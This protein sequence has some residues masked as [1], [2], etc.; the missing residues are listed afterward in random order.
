MWSST[1][2]NSRK[3]GTSWPWCGISY[4]ENTYSWFQTSH[5]DPKISADVLI[6][7]FLQC[8]ESTLPIFLQIKAQFLLFLSL[9]GCHCL[10]QPSSP[11]LPF[12]M[13][14]REPRS[15]LCRLCMLLDTSN[16]SKE[17]RGCQQTRLSQTCQ[18][19]LRKAAGFLLANITLI[20]YLIRFNADGKE[21]G[22]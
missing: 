15:H 12:L 1:W 9:S 20:T 18:I 4:S 6:L 11:P 14:R 3:L 10:H 7:R 8:T 13:H 2:W 17:S 5:S 22:Y 21:A 19:P 16:T